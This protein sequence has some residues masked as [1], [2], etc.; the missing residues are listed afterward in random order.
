MSTTQDSN[1]LYHTKIL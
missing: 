1:M